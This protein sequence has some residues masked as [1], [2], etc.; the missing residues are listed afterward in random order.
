[1]RELRVAGLVAR[2]RRQERSV[3]CDFGP[4]LPNDEFGQVRRFPVEPFGSD[5]IHPF[6]QLS[7]VV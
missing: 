6:R 4:D 5:Q 2:V 3:L 7:I 1:M